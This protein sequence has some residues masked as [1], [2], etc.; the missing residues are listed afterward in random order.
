MILH[1][2][3][4]VT[5]SLRLLQHVGGVQFTCGHRGTRMHVDIDDAF[6]KLFSVH[7]NYLLGKMPG[8]GAPLAPGAAFD[9]K[10][11]YFIDRPG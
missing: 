11:N 3:A 6:Q 5:G 2:K 8:S 1:Q 7:R 4:T 9:L 10:L